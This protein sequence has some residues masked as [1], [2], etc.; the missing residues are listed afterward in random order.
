MAP[1][2]DDAGPN[3]RFHDLRDT[4]M[5]KLEEWLLLARI[6]RSSIMCTITARRLMICGRIAGAGTSHFSIALLLVSILTIVGCG[7]KGSS[8]SNSSAGPVTASSQFL[9]V[10]GEIAGDQ[11]QI[12]GYR[13]RNDGTLASLAL[14]SLVA[15][16]CCHQG[17]SSGNVLYLADFG[18]GIAAMR[19]DPQSG[20]LSPLSGSPFSGLTGSATGSPTACGNKFIYVTNGFPGGVFAFLIDASGAL[21]QV[22]GSP[23][24]TGTSPGQPV[25][26]P[27]CSFLFVTNSFDGSSAANGGIVYAYTLDAATGILNSV[28]GSPFTVGNPTSMI[29]SVATDTTGR[30]LYV[31][32]S[33]VQAVFGFSI[34][35]TGAL[36]PLTGSP[37]TAG[38]SPIFALAV[39]VASKQFL[40]VANS[41]SNDILA[42]A[43]DNTTGNL[44]LISSFATTSQPSFLASSGSFLYSFNLVSGS[45][46]SSNV[47]VYTVNQDGTLSP[48]ATGGSL[49]YTPTSASVVT[50]P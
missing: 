40:Y 42:F 31:P 14:S 8:S 23:F 49:A 18:G 33:D 35:P 26:D 50:A 10:T 45:V 29:R 6:G 22:P 24:P 15:P 4:C 46:S 34:G 1:R 38:Q 12:F 41:G 20:Q 43:V 48:V 3:I 27:S 13:I 17:A 7:S 30:F 11:T 47:N 28:S 19:A 21:S 44:S 9:Y 32:N 37:F 36:I 5:T 39:S 2:P 25:V 16:L